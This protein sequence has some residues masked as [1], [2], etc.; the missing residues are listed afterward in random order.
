MDE[1]THDEPLAG[2]APVE[3]EEVDEAPSGQPPAVHGD[4]VDA[5]PDDP[6]FIDG[7]GSI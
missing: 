3:M 6:A 7:D 1:K 2:A 4:W 5:D